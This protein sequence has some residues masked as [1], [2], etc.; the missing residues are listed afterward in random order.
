MG[1]W[2]VKTMYDKCELR[3]AFKYKRLRNSSKLLLICCD[4]NNFWL[5]CDWLR[6]ECLLM[7]YDKLQKPSSLKVYRDK[8][9]PWGN[10]IFLAWTVI[11]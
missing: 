7:I 3:S 5:K 9:A 4:F 6:M 11:M 8:V 1:G 2:G 10:S